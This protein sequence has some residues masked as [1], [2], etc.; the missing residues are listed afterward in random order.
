MNLG[1]AMLPTDALLRRWNMSRHIPE[2]IKQDPVSRN[3]YYQRCA[4]MFCGIVRGVW[5]AEAGREIDFWLVSMVLQKLTLFH[6]V[7]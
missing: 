3:S 4:S 7:D 2:H 5:C 1:T 6:H